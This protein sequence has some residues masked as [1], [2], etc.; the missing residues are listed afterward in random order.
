MPFITDDVVGEEQETSV[1][2]STPHC[3]R[4]TMRGCGTPVVVAVAVALAGWAFD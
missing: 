2:L 4:V 1:E 3:L